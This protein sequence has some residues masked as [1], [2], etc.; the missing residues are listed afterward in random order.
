[1]RIVIVTD[2]WHPQVNGV[3][4]TLV[5]VGNAL[6]TLGHFVKYVTPADFDTI[7][8]PTYHS[9]RL[10]LWPMPKMRRLLV[11][12]RP[13]A[14]HIA[15]EGPLGLAA[16]HFCVSRQVPF[17]TSLHTQFPEYVRLRYPIPLSVSYGYLRWFHSAAQRTLV[18]TRKVREALLSRGLDKLVVW[19]RGVDVTLF[20]PVG[21][22]SL[23]MPR[24]ISMYMGRVAVEKNLDGFLKLNLPGTKVVVGDG[25]DL[26]RLRVQYP[27]AVFTGAKRGEDLVRHLSAADVFVF[28]SR[29]DTFGLVLLEAMAC[30]VPVAAYPAP[31]PIDVVQHGR[32]GWLSEDLGEAVRQA[33]R[34]NP[35]DCVAYAQTQSWHGCA[36][37]FLQ[38]LQPEARQAVAKLDWRLAAE[39]ALRMALAQ[40]RRRFRARLAPVLTSLGVSR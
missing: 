10:A 11:S 24:P 5:D 31:G 8:C 18:P 29:T 12:L 36:G 40:Q 20:R 33:L 26:A 15:T 17:T 3:V 27:N 39:K 21:K 32:T 7:P 4:T 16:R 35:K 19:S 1:M 30:G 6:R 25:P 23:D 14:V 28:P 2:A 9:I 13:D 34:L 37:Q 22:S 38:A